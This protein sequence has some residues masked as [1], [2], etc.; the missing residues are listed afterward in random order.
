M[1]YCGFKLDFYCDANPCDNN[2]DPYSFRTTIVLPCWPKRLR[3]ATFRNFVE[4]TIQTESPAHVH[5]RIVWIGIAEMQRF[6][7]AYSDWLLEQAQTEMP[8]YDKVNPLVDVL[9]TLQPC[10]TCNDDCSGMSEA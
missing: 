4:K 8:S 5:T 9:N 2:E 1:D 6:E 7:T 10:G 3:D